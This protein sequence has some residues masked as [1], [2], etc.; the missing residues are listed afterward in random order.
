MKLLIFAGT[1][2]GRLLAQFVSG[3]PNIDATICVATDYGS[4]MLGEENQNFTLISE[5]LNEEKMLCLMQNGFFDLC[6]DATHPYATRATQNIKCAAMKATLP[7]LRLLRE[8]SYLQKSRY[9]KSEAEASQIVNQEGGNVLITT[10]SKNLEA[11]T[12]IDD[13]ANRVYARVLPTIDAIQKCGNLGL[14]KSHI[15]AMQGP[16]SQA[17]NEAIMRQFDIRQ[18][19]TKDSGS[20]GGFMEK[21][22]AA[23]AC[24]VRIIIIG[25]PKDETGFS[26]QEIIKRLEEAA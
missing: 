16:F 23:N 12:C 18:L 19:V 24:G 21:I 17:L 15:I 8:E 26:L 1:T 7:Y 9:C 25:R 6:I 10:G 4:D 11:F 14:V 3:N 20:L 2:E 5:R 13:Y 22:N